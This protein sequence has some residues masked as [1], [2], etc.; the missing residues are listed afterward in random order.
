[1]YDH[2]LDKEFLTFKLGNLTKLTKLSNT[3]KDQKKIKTMS[4]K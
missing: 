3:C 4:L 1:M 2:D